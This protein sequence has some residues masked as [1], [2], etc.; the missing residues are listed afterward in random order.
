MSKN[1]IYQIKSNNYLRGLDN[2]IEIDLSDNQ[3][4]EIYLNL[5]KLTKLNLNNNKLKKIHKNQFVCLTN[6]SCLNLNNNENDSF[7][8]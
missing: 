1:R 3:L 4:Q 8:I 2:L 7:W 6:L 5:D